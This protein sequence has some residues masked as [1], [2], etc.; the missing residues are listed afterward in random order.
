MTPH[1]LYPPIDFTST[2]AHREW[3]PSLR[4]LIG[5]N[6]VVSCAYLVLGEAV[7]RLC[8]NVQY[9]SVKTVNS[10]LSSCLQLLPQSEAV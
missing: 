3:T 10:T 6:N 2:A 1:Q 7:A 4:W 9:L 8:T 5:V